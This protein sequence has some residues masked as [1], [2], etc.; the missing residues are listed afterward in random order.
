MELDERSSLLLNE[1]LLNPGVKNK[2]LEDK[3]N[4]SRRQIGYSF[5]KINDWLKSINL[6]EIKR[7]KTGL[8]VINKVLFT[9]L[10]VEKELEIKDAYILS[11]EERSN[12]I[13]IMLLSNRE[14]LSLYHFTNA[15]NVSKNTIISDLKN[16][17]NLVANFELRIKY[18]R[19]IGYWIEGNEFN[20]RKLLINTI[21]KCIEMYN[22]EEWIRELVKI[23][24]DEISKLRDRIENVERKLNLKFTDEKME[25]MPYILYLILRRV[26][27]G[28]IINSFHIH[29][30]EL[31]DTKEYQA[32]EELLFDLVQIPMEERLFITLNLLTTNV[33][34]S[35]LNI[36]DQTVPELNQA[37]DEMLSL[38]EKNACVTLQDKEQL[39]NKILLHVKPAYYRMKYK[40]SITNPLQETVSNEFKEL[41]H[42]VRKSLKPLQNLIGCE[43]PE[44]ESTYFT[45]LIGGW[46]TRQGESLQKK[47]KALVVCQKGICVSRLLESTLRELFPEFVFIDALSVREFQ[48]YN[49]DYDI[50]FSTVYLQ[51]KKKIFIVKSFLEKDEK[52]R[53]RKQ[54]MQE[55]NGYTPS[56][57]NL[58]KVIEIVE[59]HAV[60]ENK[61]ILIKDLLEHFNRDNN[62]KVSK[63]IELPKPNLNELI[64]PET[65]HLEES[66]KSWEEAFRI[67]AKLLLDKGSISS[68]YIEEM[69]KLYQDEDPYII[70]GNNVA[71]P[72]ADPKNGVNEVSMSLLKLEKPVRYN[73][74][75]INII[76]T[77]AAIDKQQH[78]RGL[79]QLMKF[80]GCKE[81]TIKITNSQSIEEIHEVL[82]KYS[83]S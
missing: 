35:E 61:D 64:L 70:I 37:L 21:L 47:V 26:K 39:L 81:D 73:D 83:I 74:Y 69:I 41:H 45:M 76:I 34:S 3:Y 71:I 55:L 23:T 18:S 40:L 58:E 10:L 56:E 66:V 12:L 65:I 31:S 75:H 16:A 42:L 53:L 6:P 36:T 80:A 49:L 67:G 63:Q 13:I 30:D 14:E 9:A 15:L 38:F 48:N 19:Q 52:Y 32:A 24:N 72:H 7:T 68:D 17:Q 82:T 77:I 22:G 50:V 28:K 60:I 79:M 44:C 11:E 5:N 43:I 57:L 8:F 20:N 2:D 1:M 25:S 78:L 51:T 27:Q 62:P 54:V 29:Y 59:K 46:L 4:L 33:S